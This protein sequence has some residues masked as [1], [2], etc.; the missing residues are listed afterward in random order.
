MKWNS[1]RQNDREGLLVS[2]TQCVL[3]LARYEPVRDYGFVNFNDPLYVM[4]NLRV[5]AGLTMEGLSLA[6]AR[7]E[8]REKGLDRGTH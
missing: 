4:E 6:S 2:L 7:E 1:P 5:Q 8:R 3:V